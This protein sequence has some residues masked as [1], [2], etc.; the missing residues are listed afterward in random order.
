MHTHST[1]LA[2]VALAVPTLAIA[3]AGYEDDDEGNNV[4]WIEHSGRL[5]QTETPNDGN[6][7]LDLNVDVQN[8]D[9]YR[10]AFAGVTGGLD[11]Y[12]VGI[13]PAL[14]FTL[15]DQGDVS[16]VRFNLVL[17]VE[18]RVSGA[19]PF[20]DQAEGPRI[21]Y[22]ANPYLGGVFEA[23]PG[24]RLGMV[25]TA[26]TS[27]NGVFDTRQEVAMTA[28]FGNNRNFLGRL[29]P[30]ALVAMQLDEGPDN[31]QG[32]YAEA[33]FRPQFDL[34]DTGAG[35]FQLEAPVF[36]G[37]AFDDYYGQT[38]DN[39]PLFVRAG[40]RGSM[41]LG[42]V[43][44]DYGT[45]RLTAG[46]DMLWREDSLTEVVFDPRADTPVPVNDVGNN[47]VW[48]GLLGLDIAY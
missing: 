5:V 39:Y 3:D 47:Y 20:G 16:A 45:W 28:G 36:A 42:M 31:S 14:A 7:H 10:G 1:L 43:S 18:N 6:A 22:R 29:Q 33:G 48:T 13:D 32:G 35:E 30:Y 12:A 8:T 44:S 19:A 40:L 24:F 34:A 23:G 37:V 25:Y 15:F 38:N 46:A 27:P 2:A 9:Y 21:W 17:G 26:Y 4:T 11:D 41:G